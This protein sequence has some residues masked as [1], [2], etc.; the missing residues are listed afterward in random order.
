LLAKRMRGYGDAQAR[1]IFRD[2]IQMPANVRVSDSG[3]AV[4]FHRRAHLPIIIASGL[5]EKK[6]A[7]PWW[8]GKTLTMTG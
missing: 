3:V 8:G 4:H 7:V 2:L 1:L 5:L 6:V